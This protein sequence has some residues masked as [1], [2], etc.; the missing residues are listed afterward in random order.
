MNFN[1]EESLSRIRQLWSVCEPVFLTDNKVYV[2]HH[3]TVAY[4]HS[5]TYIAIRIVAA[6][7]KLAIWKGE[8]R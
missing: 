1:R 2:C 6:S 3:H 4:Q 7:L 8:N 5:F